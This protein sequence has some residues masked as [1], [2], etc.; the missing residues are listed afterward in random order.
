MADTVTSKKIL[1][2]NRELAWERT[3]EHPDTIRY[4]RNPDADVL[5]PEAMNDALDDVL[6]AGML[7]VKELV[8]LDQGQALLFDDWPGNPITAELAPM[9]MRDFLPLAQRLVANLARLHTCGYVHNYVCPDAILYARESG[10]AT[11]FRFERLTKIGELGAVVRPLI[12]DAHYL[13]FTSPESTGRTGKGVDCR[14]DLYSLG[15]VFYFLTTGLPPFSSLDALATIHSHLAVEPRSPKQLNPEVPDALA[16]LIL[17]LLAKQP[18]DRYQGA[19]GVGVDLENLAGEFERAASLDE[20]RDFIPGS[21]DRSGVFR[22]PSKL[23]GRGAQLAELEKAAFGE[24][25]DEFGRTL[26]VAGESGAGKTTLIRSFAARWTSQTAGKFLYGKY[27]TVVQS[28]YQAVLRVLA[29]FA[30]QVL[31]GPTSEIDAWRARIL[32]ATPG[33]ARLFAELVPEFAALV[34]DLPELELL[35]PTERDSRFKLA[36]YDLFVSLA[37][38]DAPLLLCLDDLQWADPASLETM[39]RLLGANLP[40][41]TFVGAFRSGA[42]DEHSGLKAFLEHCAER[43]TT[44]SPIRVKRLDSEEVRELLNASFLVDRP[45]TAERDVAVEVPSRFA[46][47]VRD[48]TEGNPLF[49]T[50]LLKRLQQRRAFWFDEFVGTWQWDLDAVQGEEVSG[51]VAELL[52]VKL[53]RL[54][55]EGRSI[56]RLASCVGHQFESGRLAA[57]SD[58]SPSRNAS[59]LE[60]ASDLGLIYQASGRTGM[61]EFA[62]DQIRECVYLE[63]SDSEKE[64][65]HYRLGRR[66]MHDV[67]QEGRDDLLFQAMNHL[68]I[69]QRLLEDAET[70]DFIAVAMAAVAVA[71]QTAAYDSALEYLDAVEEHFPAAGWETQYGENLEYGLARLEAC[72]LNHRFEEAD[73]TA[74]ELLTVVREPVDRVRVY[75]LRVITQTFLMEYQKAIEVAVEGLAD[76]G[77][78][79]PKNPRLGFPLAMARMLLAERRIDLHKLDELPPIKEPT[80]E[81]ALQLLFDVAPAA[82][83]HNKAM[84][85]VLGLEMFQLMEKHGINAYGLYSVSYVSTIHSVVLKNYEKGWEIANSV[86]QMRDRFPTDSSY[87]SN[88]LLAYSAVLM[89]TRTPYEEMIPLIIEGFENSQRAAQVTFSGYY[90]DILLQLDVYMGRSVNL[91]VERRGQYEQLSRRLRFRELEVTLQ[92]TG[93]VLHFLRESVIT[94]PGHLPLDEADEALECKV[95]DVL[96]QGF[97]YLD[98]LFLA[99][100][101]ADRNL[102]GHCLAALGRLSEF[103]SAGHHRAEWLTLACIHLGAVA[104][105]EP[106]RKIRARMRKYYKELAHLADIGARAHGHRA[107]I[108]SAELAALDG[109]FSTACRFYQEALEGCEE[110]GILHMAG[111][112]AERA[113]HLCEDAGLHRQR[114]DYLTIAYQRFEAY[115]ANAKTGE[116]AVRYPELLGAADFRSSGSSAVTWGSIDAEAVTRASKALFEEVD[117]SHLIDQLLT[118]AMETGGATRGRL[119]LD[120]PSR[121]LGLAAE[122]WVEDGEIKLREGRE[123]VPVGELTRT[124]YALD[125]VESVVEMGT[126]VLIDDVSKDARFEGT[127]VSARSILCL[128][129]VDRG[130]QYAALYLE[131]HLTSSAFTED[132]VIV[133]EVL[134]SLAAISLTNAR[135]YTQQENSLKVERD[136]RASLS[137]LSDLK[138]EFLANTSHE[139]RTPLNGIIGLA[140]SMLTGDFGA[141]SDASKANLSLIVGSGRRLANLVN[142]ILDFTRL[143]KRELEIHPKSIDVEAMVSLV[144]R[145]L[146][147]D[148]TR[149]GSRGIVN[150]VDEGI[151]VEVDENRFQ[152]ILFNLVGNAIKFTEANGTVKIEADAGREYTTIRVVDDGVGIS[153]A[154]LGR[155]FEAFEQVDASTERKAGGTGLG[156]PLTKQLVELHGG[157]LDVISEPGAGSVFSFTLPVSRAPAEELDTSTIAQV[158]FAGDVE[159]P[160]GNEVTSTVAPERDFHVLVVDDEPINVRVLE[161]YLGSHYKVTSAASGVE[162]LRLVEGGLEADAILLDVMMPQMDGYETC[163]QIR[164]K[165]TATELPVILLTAKNRLEDLQAGFDAGANDYI[166]KPFARQELLARLRTQLDLANMSAAFSR[167]VPL[168]IVQFLNK[169]SILDVQL[170]DNVPMEVT[171]MFM[172]IRSYTTLAEGMTPNEAFEFLI[173]LFQQVGPIIEDNGGL[174]NQ[175]LGDGLMALFPGSPDDAV[176]AAVRVQKEVQRF[177][178]QRRKG[179]EIPIVV[180]IGL[181][182]G[183]VILGIIGDKYRRSGNVIS[184]T[185]NLASRVEGLTKTYGARIAASEETLSQVRHLDD[186]A[187]RR[188]DEVRVKGRA[189]PVVVHEIFAGDDDVQIQRKRETRS[190]FEQAARLYRQEQ[191]REAEALLE[192]ILSLNA[193]DQAAALLRQRCA[194]YAE[195]GVPL[196]WGGVEELQEK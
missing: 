39:E 44:Q 51:G 141:L 8:S 157:R 56:L 148:S 5:S 72:Y 168:E 149:L 17:K 102:G 195:H 134:L 105:A 185:V 140:D 186:D 143:Q 52:Q 25:D 172:D 97:F 83:L 153:S 96:E 130:E 6:D 35:G 41:L 60:E 73:R 147:A 88:F 155:I 192:E 175:F 132:R 70:R 29:D 59:A 135:L 13:Q 118:L 32:E 67:L 66:F 193:D 100:I 190:H 14:S 75:R 99:V 165:H 33:G 82:F 136:A 79:I 4:F 173:A 121:G 142:D 46:Q 61:W 170:G 38:A 74:E 101:F 126:T 69:G 138:D 187:H 128:P 43:L 182:T 109:D 98:Y 90:A 114:D 50:E 31:M 37:R 34:G 64:I 160:I 104:G 55:L 174:V 24:P 108:A 120:T 122:A 71:K 91:M 7:K 139:L 48:K 158:A 124:D 68:L 86:L 89:W 63:L 152:Q 84:S 115:G 144:C 45:G 154:D 180:G 106:D 184:D 163:R 191:F 131:N 20:L 151:L 162:C 161:N 146:S 171:V 123:D 119:F 22:I 113:A 65:N 19:Y 95:D 3:T 76:L 15:A 87:K 129:I 112:V 176:S 2:R 49:V 12:S 47:L 177:N 85:I 27:D 166:P 36:I 103:R 77:I 94:E 16:A 92:I 179:G 159:A 164:R 183:Q 57:I 11:F 26:F 111:I 28:P 42:E 110:R 156:L 116:L 58:L 137:K 150:D 18:E 167:F 54:S 133:L 1:V 145:L 62:H 53:E 125:L 40:H 81:A 10:E 189:S 188:L 117:L 169:Q 181:H 21:D 23:F 127:N 30:S 196:D 78:K 93:R 9:P 194:Y 80:A 107:S 178:A